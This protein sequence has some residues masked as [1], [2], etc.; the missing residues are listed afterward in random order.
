MELLARGDPLGTKYDEEVQDRI[1]RFRRAVQVHGALR[2]GARH[3]DRP[4][5]LPV[6]EREHG[7]DV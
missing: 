6:N 2:T 4:V 7:E 3:L 5:Q 1:Y